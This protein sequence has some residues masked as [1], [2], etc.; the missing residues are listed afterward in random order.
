[1]WLTY[2]K[3]LLLHWKFFIYNNE[4]WRCFNEFEPEGFK[5]IVVHGALNSQNK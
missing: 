4:R 3:V 1:M 5:D 2:R